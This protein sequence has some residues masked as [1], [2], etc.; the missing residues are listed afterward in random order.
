[1]SIISNKN[2]QIKKKKKYIYIL[3]FFVGL[4]PATVC[5]LPQNA[6]HHTTVSGY[7][8]AIGPN[9]FDFNFVFSG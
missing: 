5:A 4:E 9:R 2:N 6:L 7:G 8:R 1:M 3:D